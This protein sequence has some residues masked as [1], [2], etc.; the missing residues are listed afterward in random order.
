MLARR[1]Q[2][3]LHVY[4]R[5][6]SQG[7]VKSR[8]AQ[9]YSDIVPGMIPIA[10]IGSTVYVALQLVRTNLSHERYLEE[11]RAKV[12]ALEERLNGLEMKA[13]SNRQISP[14]SSSKK[15]WIF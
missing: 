6:Y 8:H 9:W 10:L 11:A 14:N 1:F 4:S 5:A 15:W 13:D 7:S 2:Q 12:K 3:Q